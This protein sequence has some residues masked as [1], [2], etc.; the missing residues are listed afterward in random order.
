MQRA[1]IEEVIRFVVAIIL[2]GVIMYAFIFF[3]PLG[4]GGPKHGVEIKSIIKNIPVVC[5]CFFKVSI[6]L[7]SLAFFSSLAIGWLSTKISWV[8]MIFTFLSCFPVFV[9]GIWILEHLPCWQPV[10]FFIIAALTIGLC[11]AFFIE[12]YR[13][14]E[15]E[16]DTVGNEAYVLMAKANGL[17]GLKLCWYVKS[18]IIIHLLKLVTSKLI[19]L[20]S[21]AVIVEWIFHLKGIGNLVIIATDDEDIELLIAVEM[22]IVGFAILC[23]FA[24]R[25]LDRILDPRLREE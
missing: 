7:V 25:M 24:N 1:V 12:L 19:V 14:T 11:D 21:S 9:A 2:C 15:I 16:V 23:C 10:I 8:K 6:P 3:G 20:L 18:D 4:P 13:H 22:F 17:K 5:G